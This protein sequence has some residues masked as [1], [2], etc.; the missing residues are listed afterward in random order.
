MA[1]EVDGP[2]GSTRL[3]PIELEGLRRPHIQTRAQL[4]EAEQLN[5]QQ[6]HLW[7]SRARPRDVLS[8]KF[9]LTVHKRMFSEVWKWAGTFRRTE[10]NIGCDPLQIAIR[11]RQLL[12]D[13]R[14]WLEH[15]TFPPDEIG[16]RYH[17]RLVQIHLFANGNGRH[18]RLV[19]DD[20]LRRQG[21]DQLTWGE[22]GPISAGKVR[23]GYIAALRAADARDM[24][25]L[26]AFIR[27]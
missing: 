20:L 11:T 23:A 18:A 19:V 10:K 22:G 2:F 4:D 14:Y 6:A 26:L 13:V 21:V 16:A 9:L 8:E 15:K 25:P 24:A 3:D 7:L 5:I 1:L 27:S 17:H 12:D